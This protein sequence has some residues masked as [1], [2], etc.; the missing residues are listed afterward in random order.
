MSENVIT[1]VRSVAGRDCRSFGI[2][3]QAVISAGNGAVDHDTEL[4]GL[5]RLE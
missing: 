3:V 5:R 2:D 4:H 1:T